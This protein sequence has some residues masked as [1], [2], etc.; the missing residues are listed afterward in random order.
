MYF[1]SIS[2]SG[3][4]GLHLID[5]ENEDAHIEDS[6]QLIIQALTSMAKEENITE[7]PSRCSD[8]SNPWN[9]GPRILRWVAVF[10]V[11]GFRNQHI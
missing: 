2:P 11:F 4:I 5:A 8:A 6:V 9:S 7:A 10:S 1:I 3:A